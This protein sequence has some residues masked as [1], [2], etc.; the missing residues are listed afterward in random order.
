MSNAIH[1]YYNTCHSWLKEKY[2]S[3]HVE[4]RIQFYFVFCLEFVNEYLNK[5]RS[6][7]PHENFDLFHI[8]KNLTHANSIF[9]SLLG[10]LSWNFYSLA[11]FT[12]DLPIQ[13]KV[14]RIFSFHRYSANFLLIAFWNLVRNLHHWVI[15]VIFQNGRKNFLQ[16]KK[17]YR[18]DLSEM[19]LWQREARGMGN[20][21]SRSVHGEG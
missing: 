17:Q 10:H 13:Y 3:N 16:P 8:Y 1:P 20:V 2:Y 11:G 7:K 19:F 14:V 5:S 21:L 18:N 6:K 4:Y 12:L 15:H 9:C